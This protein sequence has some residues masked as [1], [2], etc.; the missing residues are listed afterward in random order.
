MSN[1]LTVK[2]LQ[3]LVSFFE[4]TFG[5]DVGPTDALY[6]ADRIQDFLT[7]PTPPPTVQGDN[8]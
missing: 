6:V 4:R 2:D 1:K 3:G 8:Q 5:V 7:Y